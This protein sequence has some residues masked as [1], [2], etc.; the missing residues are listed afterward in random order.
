MSSGNPF[1][2]SIQQPPSNATSSFAL[3][4]DSATPSDAPGDAD[5]PKTSKIKNVRIVSPSRSPVENPSS[6]LLRRLSTGSHAGSPPPS[7]TNDSP[8]SEESDPFEPT[9]EEGS[10]E[11]SAVLENTRQNSGTLDSP[12]DT[13]ESAS[14]PNPFNKTLAT[15]DRSTTHHVLFK[16]QPEVIDRSMPDRTAGKGTMDVD[17]FKRLLMTG[18]PEEELPLEAV[19]QTSLTS[20]SYAQANAVAASSN[21]TPAVPGD[22]SSS[23]DTS[24]LSRQSIFEPVQE[25]HGE[26]PRTSYE[27]SVSDDDERANLVGDPSRKRERKKAPPPQLPRHRHGKLVS[28][29]APQTVAFD[30]FADSVNQPSTIVTRPHRSESD[31]N[32][33]LPPPPTTVSLHS[34]QPDINPEQPS[35][36]T[37]SENVSA[38]KSPPTPTVTPPSATSPTQFKSNPTQPLSR[39]PSVSKRQPPAPPVSRRHS[40][41]RTESPSTA[42]LPTYFQQ[43][44]RSSSTLSQSSAASV[45]ATTS[46][47]TPTQSPP[48]PSSHSVNI[49]S[50][51]KM[52]PPPPPTRRS[53][54]GSGSAY[55]PSPALTSDME[56]TRNKSDRP[57]SVR[58]LQMTAR[59]TSYAE[60]SSVK[61]VGIASPPPPPPRRTG[62]AVMKLVNEGSAS[63]GVGEGKGMTAE[64]VTQG[65]EGEGKD[66]LAEIEAFQREVDELRGKVGA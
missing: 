40:Q 30:T 44:H 29:R 7:P 1:R 36:D 23:A 33:P 32:K 15:M 52:A 12:S 49:L 24:S 51:Y 58:S 46:P 59:R 61:S 53:G 63:A 22:S 34:P 13:P 4:S 43:R 27:I 5:T 31:L 3:D 48:Q 47:Q 62:E 45:S 25:T 9:L 11:S 19:R 56:P 16:S 18:K 26:T 10:P 17:S 39:E 20:I 65:E 66:L 28:P 6:N 2:R 21:S 14:I 41:L 64:V 55:N 50:P 57:S 37:S 38:S 35:P 8:E 60:T 54:G 42:S